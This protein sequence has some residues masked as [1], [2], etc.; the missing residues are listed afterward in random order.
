MLMGQ[1]LV[2]GQSQW[3]HPH[4][5][6]SESTG[7]PDRAMRVEAIRLSIDQNRVHPHR[8]YKENTLGFTVAYEAFS[9]QTFLVKCSFMGR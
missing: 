8:P 5:P 9:I 6:P 1:V 2:Y 4:R 3:Y 7:S